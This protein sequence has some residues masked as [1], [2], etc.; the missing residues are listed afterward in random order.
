MTAVTHGTINSLMRQI[1]S[2]ELRTQR[3][4]DFE[5]ALARAQANVGIV[6][7]DDAA[8]IEAACVVANF[9]TS[10]LSREAEFAGNLAIPLVKQLT[11]EVAK[12][13]VE[14]AKFVHWGATSQDVIDTALMLQ[15]REGLRAFDV[16]LR[17]LSNA[18]IAKI[19]QH[20]NTIM[21]GRTLLQQALPIT[22]GFKMAGWL[23]GITR[24][25]QR[26][27]EVQPRALLLQFGGAVGTLASLGNQG[28][29][30]AKELAREL[31]LALPDIAWHG[32]RDRTVEVATLLGLITG[33]LGKIARDISLSMQ[34][35]IGELSEPAQ[36]GRG[37]SSTMPHKRNP[38]ACTAILSAA[39]RVPGL[40]AT[41][42][43]AMPQEHE[44]GLGGW[45]AEWD[46]LPEIFDVAFTALKNAIDVIEGLEIDAK[47][48]AANL[49]ASHGLIMAEAVSMTLAQ[50]VGKAEAHRIVE[51]A[52]HRAQRDGKPLLEF[53]VED[54]NVRA[55]LST[56]QLNEVM[57][58]TNY[59]GA[60]EEIIEQVLQKAGEI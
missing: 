37:G 58:P 40:V 21:V 20:R 3:M 55:H 17:K 26:L 23:D 4:L 1:F 25:R 28:Q 43:S 15:M 18:L 39:I 11:A 38:V 12:Q 60:T 7:N 16:E 59:L 53:L 31:D 45:Q 6:P 35:E 47:R 46:T 34:T 49:N 48:M 27:T 13:N 33:S 2:L 29:V 32:Q 51:Q 44:R 54:V 8:A 41:M 5:A 30:V 19:K 50:F 24:H 56:S 10:A 9:D 14:A 57:N 22:L 52:C 36:A 42:L